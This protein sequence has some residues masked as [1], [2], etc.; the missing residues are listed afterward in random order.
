MWHFYTFHLT[1]FTLLLGGGRWSD[2]INGKGAL[3]NMGWQGPI[4]S[5]SPLIG[6]DFISQKC[7]ILAF[8]SLSL[9]RYGSHCSLG[10]LKGREN[11]SLAYRFQFP[12]AVAA[13]YKVEKQ[14]KSRKVYDWEIIVIY[15]S[16]VQRSSVQFHNGWLFCSTIPFEAFFTTMWV[17]KAMT[18]RSILMLVFWTK[19]CDKCQSMLNIFCMD[20]LYFLLSFV[21][22]N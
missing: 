19:S 4:P 18:L 7:W 21:S 8:F 16:T 17:K 15:I 20:T 1:L 22:W 14:L 11:V 5:Q 10:T 2:V 6:Q 12:L 3:H 9:C 13:C